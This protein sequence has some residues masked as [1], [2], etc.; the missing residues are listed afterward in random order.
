MSHLGKFACF[1]SQSTM[2]TKLFIYLRL[3]VILLVL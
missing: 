3:G 2:T 1:C